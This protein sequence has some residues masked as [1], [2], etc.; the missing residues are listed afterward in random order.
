M[1]PAASDPDPGSPFLV[2]DAPDARTRVIAVAGE[3]DMYSAPLLKRAIVAAIE[4]G[5]RNVVLDLTETGFV[6]SG[7]LAVFISAHKRLRLVD[8]RLVI[9]N[10][11]P[12]TARV[13]A[14]TGLDRAFSILATRQ[15]ALRALSAP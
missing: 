7:G 2:E 11:E 4:R 8:G 14:I 15:A 9:V 3:L 12:S 1:P 5:T 6:D 10:T 13:L